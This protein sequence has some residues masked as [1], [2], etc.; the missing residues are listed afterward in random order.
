MK[1]EH[2]NNLYY[3]NREIEVIIDKIELLKL[4]KGRLMGIIGKDD[5]IESEIDNLTA[6]LKIQQKKCLLERKMM[7]KFISELDDSQMRMIVSLRYINGL[8][9]QQIA[10]SIG[11]FD[12]SYPRK[13]HKKFLKEYFNDEN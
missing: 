5:E 4:K 9:W 1:K 13:K 7:E 3:L 8:S 11:E 6:M 2:L 12:E 10:F